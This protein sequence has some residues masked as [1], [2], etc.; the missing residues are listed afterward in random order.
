MHHSLSFRFLCIFTGVAALLINAGMIEWNLKITS[1]VTC[2]GM[3][4]ILSNSHLPANHSHSFLAVL[5]GVDT[6]KLQINKQ[7]SHLSAK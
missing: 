7:K 5:L 6:P 4:T 3:M 2:T 1:M